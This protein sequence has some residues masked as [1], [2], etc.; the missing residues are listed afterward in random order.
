[1]QVYGLEIYNTVDILIT[2]NFGISLSFPAG[3]SVSLFND[4]P[5]FKRFHL[6]VN[7]PYNLKMS[8]EKCVLVQKS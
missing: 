4:A 2:F 5:N 3:A 6:Q 8:I 7:T 1:M